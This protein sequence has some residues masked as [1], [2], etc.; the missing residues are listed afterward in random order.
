MS[1]LYER[2]WEIRDICALLKERRGKLRE[3]KGDFDPGEKDVLLDIRNRIT[4]LWELKSW[5]MPIHCF[6][7]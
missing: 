1:S 6:P 2:G 7:L 5:A 4:Q 3:G